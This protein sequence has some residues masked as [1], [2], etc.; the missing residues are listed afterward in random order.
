MLKLKYDL[1]ELAEI[2]LQRENRDYSILKVLDRAILIRK[3]LDRLNAIGKVK[4]VNNGR[5]TS[6][7][8]KKEKR[9][10]QYLKNEKGY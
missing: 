3:E 5:L 6:L 8:T 4:N 1:F 7:Y 2:Q 10:I 9:R